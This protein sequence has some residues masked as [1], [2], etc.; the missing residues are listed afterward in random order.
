MMC[1][2]HSITE[3]KLASLHGQ[4]QAALFTMAKHYEALAK[5]IE[6]LQNPYL[7]RVNALR[8][9]DTEDF[10]LEKLKLL[11]GKSHWKSDQMRVEQ[12]RVAEAAAF[13]AAELPIMSQAIRYNK[14]TNFWYM[15]YPSPGGNL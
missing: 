11:I 13:D 10:C 8:V 14:T 1:V 3:Q 4:D 6:D 7:N 15:N 5:A 9:S 2:L 12:A